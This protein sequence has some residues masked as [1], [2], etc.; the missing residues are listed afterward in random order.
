MRP[1]HGSCL[2]NTRARLSFPVTTGVK[3]KKLKTICVNGEYDCMRSLNVK[4]I[5]NWSGCA[6]RFP[7]TTGV[8][9]NEELRIEELNTTGQQYR[10]K[11]IQTNP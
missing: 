10:T 5:K 3:L 6:G 9:A 2:R 7:V 4:R 1:D 8:I 11:N